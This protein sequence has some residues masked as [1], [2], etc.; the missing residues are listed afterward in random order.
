MQEQIDKMMEDNYDISMGDSFGT[1][2]DMIRAFYGKKMRWIVAIVWFWSLVFLAL[3]IVSL[4]IFINS[5]VTKTQIICAAIFVSGWVGIG[6]AKEM[7]WSMVNKNLL[8][9]EIKRLEIR[10]AELS[11]IVRNK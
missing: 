5:E 11:E 10:V 6:V 9:R 7:A 3:I 1:Y 4:V 8:S 2:M